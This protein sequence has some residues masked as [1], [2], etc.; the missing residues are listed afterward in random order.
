[1]FCV[2][3][4]FDLIIHMHTA[5]LIKE[6]SECVAFVRDSYIWGSEQTW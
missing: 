3:N 4:H 5:A 1:M 6:Y 2:L